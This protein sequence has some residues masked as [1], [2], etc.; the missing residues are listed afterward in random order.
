L[1]AGELASGIELSRRSTSLLLTAHHD[2]S[3]SSGSCVLEHLRLI[4]RCAHPDIAL[5][6]VGQD[7]WHGLRMNR[8]DYRIR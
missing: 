6:I 2:F 8:L 4:P 1:A 5:F 7:H 3:A